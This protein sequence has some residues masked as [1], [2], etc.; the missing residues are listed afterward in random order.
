MGGRKKLIKLW[1]KQRGKCPVCNESIT[2]ETG[3]RM[4][5]EEST[6]NKTIVHPECHKKF[7]GFI[8]TPVELAL[9]R[10]ETAYECLSRVKGN[11]HARFLGEK[12]Q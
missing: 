3:W 5:T 9:H 1:N 6:N 7:H 10:V 12:G 11:F 4:H 8:P 2:K